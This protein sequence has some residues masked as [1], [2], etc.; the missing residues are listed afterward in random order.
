[1]LTMNIDKVKTP[2]LTVSMQNNP[3]SVNVVSEVDLKAYLYEIEGNINS[4]YI[5]QE[6][7][8][9]KKLLLSDLKDGSKLP[10]V[11]LKQT[12][13]VRIK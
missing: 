5:E 9:D 4:Y 8:L 10:G 7:K 1:M 11:E 12:K 6:P 3:P 13:G 2:I